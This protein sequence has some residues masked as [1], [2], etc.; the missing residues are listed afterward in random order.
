M[1]VYARL[2][3]IRMAA[4]LKLGALFGAKPQTRRRPARP[5]RRSPERRVCP[6]LGTYNK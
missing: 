3:F 5:E 4:G 6:S 2:L 1:R